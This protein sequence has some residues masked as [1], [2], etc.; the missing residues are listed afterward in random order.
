MC[1]K[2]GVLCELCRRH[3][4]ISDHRIQAKKKQEDMA[5]KMKE[6][7]NKKFKPAEVGDTVLVPTPDVDRGK[8]DQTQIPALI[9]SKNYQT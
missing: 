9:L 7:S 6:L 8:I 1:R 4:S 5:E 2:H 3:Q